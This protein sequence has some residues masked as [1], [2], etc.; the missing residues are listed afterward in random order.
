MP[1]EALLALLLTAA[2]TESFAAKM[3]SLWA[4]ELALGS[5]HYGDSKKSVLA[6]LGKPSSE[7][8]ANVKDPE[9][10]YP[11]LTITFSENAEVRYVVSS[12]D[13]YCTPSY[14]CPG[15]PFS[16]AQDSYGSIHILE[17]SGDKVSAY[18]GS[19]LACKLTFEVQQGIIKSIGAGCPLS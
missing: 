16:R 13:A 19:K 1:H 18:F 7:S 5:I 9:S 11:G 8:P 15:M 4:T 6:L 14:V 17:A 2:A 10:K 12:S 3:Q